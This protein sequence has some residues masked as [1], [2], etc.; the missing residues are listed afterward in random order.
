[1]ISA[2]RKFSRPR[3]APPTAA[4]K[5]RMAVRHQL[6]ATAGQHRRPDPLLPPVMVRG[7]GKKIP[8]PREQRGARKEA[9]HCQQQRLD[10]EADLGA[11]LAEFLQSLTRDKFMD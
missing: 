10:A 11:L 9:L 3:Q 5:G 1:M 2:R 4:N 8:A 7:R 6:R